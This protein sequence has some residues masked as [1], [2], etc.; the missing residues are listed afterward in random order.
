MTP[1]FCYHDGYPMR[2]PKL[3]KGVEHGLVAYKCVR[4]GMGRLV[5][6]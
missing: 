2:A 5:E 6:I 4:C 3:P 1:Q